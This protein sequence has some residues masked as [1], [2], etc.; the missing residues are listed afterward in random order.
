MIAKTNRK[1]SMDQ[2]QN[3]DVDYAPR[4]ATYLQDE[5]IKKLD[6]IEKLLL[7]Y[8]DKNLKETL[9]TKRKLV[10]EVQ[11]KDLCIIFTDLRGFT[12]LSM[13]TDL[14]TLTNIANNYYDIVIEHTNAN[15]GIVDKLMGD[16]AMCLF[17]VTGKG[18]YIQQAV[19]AA[20]G[21]LVDFRSMIGSQKKHL[22]LGI[23]LAA[24]PTVVGTFGNG[25]YNSFTALGT[26]VNMAS[27]IQGLATGRDILCNKRVADE[28]DRDEIKVKGEYELKGI[29][30][31]TKVYYIGYQP[32]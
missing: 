2:L 9:L 31:K 26:T 27:R 21:I 13:R 7:P 15:G 10:T 14:R 12:N 17:G 4:L 5:R 22:A 25:N 29:N 32:E 11:E 28:L 18:D 23:G 20:R 19:K 8:I 3:V 1:V 16:G 24:G 6:K 30:R